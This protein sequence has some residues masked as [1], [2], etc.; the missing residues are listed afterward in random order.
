MARTKE[1]KASVRSHNIDLTLDFWARE[2]G[3]GDLNEKRKKKKF[4][5]QAPGKYRNSSGTRH[6][7]VEQQK[8]SNSPFFGFFFFFSLSVQNKYKRKEN[9]P[10]KHSLPH[11]V[12]LSMRVSFAWCSHDGG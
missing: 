9:S 10:L 3:V 7:R 1:L 12:G 2:V 8:Y 4:S 11:E 6:F 5:V